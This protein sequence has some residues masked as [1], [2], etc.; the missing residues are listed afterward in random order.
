LDAFD[1]KAGGIE[2]GG[3]PLRVASDGNVEGSKFGGGTSSSILFSVQ[4]AEFGGEVAIH[5]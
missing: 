1:G 3:S 4:Q 2:M 5:G